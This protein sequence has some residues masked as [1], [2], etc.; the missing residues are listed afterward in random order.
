MHHQCVLYEHQSDTGVS[1]I[2][3]LTKANGDKTTGFAFI[4]LIN[5]CRSEPSQYFYPAYSM[6]CCYL[7]YISPLT[8]EY[9]NLEDD[10]HYCDAW[11]IVQY[12]LKT[13]YT[14]GNAALQLTVLVMYCTVCCVHVPQLLI[15]CTVLN[16][17]N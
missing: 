12:T 8:I 11:H 14:S 15:M 10:H 6:Y 13:L 2:M 9:D 17:L 7:H 3:Q 16:C 1:V 4:V 5:L